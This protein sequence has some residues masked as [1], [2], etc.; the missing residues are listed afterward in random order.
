M[1][2]QNFSI[3]GY[4]TSPREV[5]DG[6]VQDAE[7]EYG[8]DSYNGTIS[9]CSLG[10]MKKVADKYTKSVD[11]KAH[12]IIEDEDYGE[13][14]EARVL[15]LGV[16]RY[17][18]YSAKK[19]THKAKRVA[20]YRQRFVVLNIDPFGKDKVVSHFA[21][22]KEAD[23]EALRLIAKYP[24]NDYAVAKRSININNGDDI[25]TDFKTEKKI[26]ASKPKSVPKGSILRE[27]HKYVFYGWA[28][29]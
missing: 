9:T 23:D 26:R 8:H 1:G 14:W 6:L 15:D 19:V 11:D 25:V 22:K 21:T 20:E 28:A 3:V 5:F 24:K 13:K 7:Y 27:V 17:E 18:L 29:C 4:G 2:A 10:R 12:K 16:V